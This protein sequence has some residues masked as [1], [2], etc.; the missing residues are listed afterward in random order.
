MAGSH[1]GQLVVKVAADF[2]VE[3][4]VVQEKLKKEFFGVW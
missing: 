1:H 4:D 3:S 2:R